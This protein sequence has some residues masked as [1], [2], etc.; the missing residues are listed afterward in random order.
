MS[1]I[2]F[3]TRA[4]LLIWEADALKKRY[5]KD[6]LLCLFIQAFCNKMVYVA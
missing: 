4:E 1:E 5:S 3:V 2:T 6:Q